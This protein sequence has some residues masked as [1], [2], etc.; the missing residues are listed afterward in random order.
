KGF[1]VV[2][3]YLLQRNVI[4]VGIPLVGIPLSVVV[5]RQTTLIVGRH[6]R[7]VFRNE[8]RIIEIA[9]NLTAKS[10]HPRLM[11]WVAWFVVMADEKASDDETSLLRHIVSLVQKRH[12]VVDDE[13]A[14]LITIDPA[15]VW[16]QLDAVQGDLSDLI[17]VAEQVAAVDGPANARERAVIAE[18]R[19]RCERT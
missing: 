16:R 15:E 10:R 14:R 7:A 12:Q 8:A 9:D 18:V 19:R 3:K 4:K 6:A 17:E 5:N 2:G 13:L 1:P 11:L